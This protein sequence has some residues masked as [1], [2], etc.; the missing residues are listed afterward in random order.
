MFMIIGMLSILAGLFVYIQAS[1]L[2]KISLISSLAFD[3][4]GAFL[5]VSFAFIFAGAMMMACRD[6]QRGSLL[7]AA[8]IAYTISFIVAVFHFDTGDLGLWTVVS[9][10]M[11]IFI[12]VWSYFHQDP[13][14]FKPKKETFIDPGMK[15][16][17]G[18]K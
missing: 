3:I 9:A 10:G 1:A 14:K 13:E 2:V 5:L 15:Q 17:D 18:Q 16:N 6:G 7:T 12:A 11:V 4:S 8:V